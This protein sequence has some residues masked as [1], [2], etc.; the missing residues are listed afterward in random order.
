MTGLYIS[1]RIVVKLTSADPWNSVQLLTQ[2]GIPLHRLEPISEMEIVI[3][4]DQ[5]FY[6]W[7][8][9][10]LQK[11]GDCLSVQRTTG[12]QVLI[13]NLCTRPILVSAFLMLISLMCILPQKI[14]FYEVE[15]NHS[16]S[17]KRILEAAESCGLTIW[18]NRRDVRSEK[19]KNQLL[20]AVPELKWAGIN[21]YGSRA[22]ISVQERAA[23]TK[24]NTI[25]SV[26]SIIASSDGIIRSISVSQG[27]VQCSEGQA[28]RGGQLLISGYADC[29]LCIRAGRAEGEIYADTVHY[30]GSV[31]PT[32][33]IEKGTIQREQK[34][35]SLVVGKKRINLWKDSGIWDVG[36]DRIRKEFCLTFPGGYCLPIAVQVETVTQRSERRSSMPQQSAAQLLQEASQKY[37]YQQM[38]AGKIHSAKETVESFPGCVRL[39]GVYNSIEMIGRERFEEIGDYYGKNN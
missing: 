6:A 17:A 10:T 35:I 37:L 22:V 33:W 38:I 24:E 9:Y 23:L 32:E 8:Q 18:A 15:G 21:T 30:L 3:E 11:K 13:R 25:H 1:N 14:L 34:S 4:T 36:C 29:G 7:I 5:K 26:S 12:P 39:N 28:V 19:L 31:T 2:R 16:I 27:T 20:S